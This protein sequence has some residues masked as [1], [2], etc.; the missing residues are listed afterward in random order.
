MSTIHQPDDKAFKLL[1]QNQK[2]FIQLLKTFLSSE[3]VNGI[4]EH[5]L[6]RIDKSFILPN[7]KSQ[8]SDIIYHCKLKGT[9]II[10][11]VLLELQSTV[12][13]QMSWRLLQYMV[14]LWRTVHLETDPQALR[15]KAFRLPAII[16]IVVYN[17]VV[18]WSAK[19]QFK[20]YQASSGIFGDSILNFRY[21]LFDIKR[22]SPENTTQLKQL[23]PLAL[24]LENTDG[25]NNLLTRFQESIDAIRQ[26]EE[27][28]FDMLK[29][30]MY[31]ILQPM[32]KN[33]S[34]TDLNSLLD[35]LY[36]NRGDG[37][38]M[39]SSISRKIYQEA[40]AIRDEGHKTGLDEGVKIGLDEGIKQ[41]AI[42]ML[43]DG[44]EPHVISKYTGLSLKEI[45]KLKANGPSS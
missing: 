5:A 13:Q 32:A 23:L 30:F 21:H 44:V 25:L 10:F 27:Q 17:G 7:Y 14:E 18:R 40:L 43:H 11:Y 9:D 45:D 16:P 42:S 3:W 37:E 36:V 6:R 2:A 15:R 12:D 38:E 22:W 33:I 31:G 1:L 20:D 28:E 24:H 4:D 26:L 29:H 39:V 35:D 19:T 34:Q 8:E 41:V